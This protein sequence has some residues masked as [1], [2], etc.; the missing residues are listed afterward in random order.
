[1]LLADIKAQD[2][3]IRRMEIMGEASAYV[4]GLQEGIADAGW[5]DMTK[6]AKLL[7]S[8]VS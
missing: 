6:D 4:S 1:M 8:H 2:A 3:V 7:H 5:K